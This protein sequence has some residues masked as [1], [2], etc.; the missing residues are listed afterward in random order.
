MSFLGSKFR[1]ILKSALNLLCYCVFKALIFK[2]FTQ[3][4]CHYGTFLCFGDDFTNELT[5]LPNKETLGYTLLELV[6]LSGELPTNQLTRL[7]GGESYKLNVAKALKSQ[8][9]LRTYYKDGLRGFRVTAKA[10]KYLLANNPK[11]FSFPLVTSAETSHIKSEIT[12]RLRL[13]RIAETTLTM[14]NADI[15][16]YPDE[17]P[18]IFSPKWEKGVSL[19]VKAPAFYNSRE[20]KEIGTAFVK[21]KGARSVGILFTPAD[22]FVIYNIGDSLMKWDYKSEMRT[23]AL[24]KTVICRERLPQQYPPEAVNGIVFGNDMTLCYDILSGE[25]GKQYFILDG[26]YEKFYYLTSDRKGERLLSLLCNKAENQKLVD[27]LMTDLYEGNIGSTLENDA[28]DENGNPVLFAY[29][30]DLPRIRRFD[31]AIRLQNK[32]GT[33]ICFDFQGEALAKYL[34]KNIKIQTIDFDKWERSMCE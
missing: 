30:C 18:Y 17:K 24:V 4:T 23:K 21:I 34:D 12:R 15:R 16:I 14:F 3:V 2:K 29:F 26:N 8:K 27:I 10:K 9:L 6:A 13:H 32:I 1:Y 19:P 7:F 33:L 5:T 31:T 11:R 28:F 25:T 20:I 22:V